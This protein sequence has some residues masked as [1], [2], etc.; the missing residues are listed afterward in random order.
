MTTVREALEDGVA[1]LRVAGSESAR[2]DAELLLGHVLGLD[3][4]QVLTHP[5]A[6]IGDGQREHFD[7]LLARREAGE[8]VA[9]IRGTKEFFGLA[10][11]VDA[12]ALIPRPES[13][14]L[15]EIALE[16]IVE[17]L[18][19]RP[20]PPGSRPLRVLDVGT[21][22]GALAIALAVTLRRRGYGAE[23]RFVASDSS[24]EALQLALEN[25]VGH[26][27]A[28][29]IDFRDADLIEPSVQ[30]GGRA[31]VIVANLPYIPSQVL[32]GLPIAASF[33]PS[34]ALD[35]G[36]D[37]LDV[38]RR[39]LDGLPDGLEREGVAL[40][41]IGGDQ[42]EPLG[43]AMGDRLPAWTLTIHTDLAGRDR[44]AELRPPQA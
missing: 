34:A 21:G 13:E 37:G 33:E 44:V 38:V 2:L 26:G 14:R 43:V 16:R 20:R 12:R 40:L 5:E 42:A 10:F 15:V 3:R 1:R 39:L 31:D 28:D 32:P 41:E 27:V 29:V 18:T 4:T 11:N 25:A 30:V 17:A 23:A 35:G 9:Y 7:G 22:S 24:A 6:P 8:P 19:S 36:P